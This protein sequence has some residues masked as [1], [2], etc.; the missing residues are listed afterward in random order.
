M[1]NKSVI[2]E[3]SR[4]YYILVTELIKCLLYQKYFSFLSASP[5][6]SLSAHSAA[7]NGKVCTLRR[8]GM[9]QTELQPIGLGRFKGNFTTSWRHGYSSFEAFVSII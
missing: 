9:Q 3:L 2:A 8:E 4:L 1:E 7:L 6:T 5:S